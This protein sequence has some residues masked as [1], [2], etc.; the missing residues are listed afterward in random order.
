IVVV[1]AEQCFRADV[2]K[3]TRLKADVGQADQGKTMAE[4][5]KTVRTCSKGHRFQKSSDCPTCPICEAERKPDVGFLSNLSAP[6][7]RALEN[8]GIMTLTKLSK[9]TE[10]EILRLHG[11]GPSSVPKLKANLRG[12]GLSFLAPR[13]SMANNVLKRRRAKRARP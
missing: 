8:E 12:E 5:R 13:Q 3:R 1:L 2:R 11:M 7:R 6:A 10:N 9:Y 4:A